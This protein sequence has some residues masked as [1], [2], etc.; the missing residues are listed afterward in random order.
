MHYRDS[1]HSPSPGCSVQSAAPPSPVWAHTCREEGSHGEPREKQLLL[2]TEPSA[3]SF[4]CR[5]PS[6]P[7]LSA[8]TPL[9]LLPH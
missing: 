9:L 3:L 4:S 8:L 1:A 5:Q 7:Q 6:A 2:P